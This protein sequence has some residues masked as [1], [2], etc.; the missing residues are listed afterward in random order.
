MRTGSVAQHDE[1]RLRVHCRGSGARVT[2]PGEV[3]R[4]QRA[5]GWFTARD[6]ALILIGPTRLPLRNCEQCDPKAEEYEPHQG[7]AD[8]PHELDVCHGWQ[9]GSKNPDH[10]ARLLERFPA[11]N[12]GVVPAMSGLVVI[13]LDANKKDAPVPEQY[14]A[15]GGITDGWDVFAA[16]LMRYAAPWPCDTLTVGTP[17]GGLHLWWKV[18]PDLTVTSTSAG[19]FG[20]LVDVRAAGSY[21]P[22]PGTKVRGGEYRRHGDVVEPADAPGWLLHHLKATGHMPQAAKPRPA[23]RHRPRADGGQVGQ[24]RLGRIAD[25]LVSAP[26]HTGHAALCTATTAAAHLVADGL[27]PEDE[28]ASVILDAGLSRNRAEREIRDAWRTALNK[29]GRGR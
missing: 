23:F 29:I 5:T 12:L 11:A 10:I 7:V 14:R 2:A 18:K 21:V 25:Q 22:A 17:S 16:V 9:A 24:E 13:D 15:A 27:V 6:C 26:A 4:K 3:A 19:Q 28:A 20:W 1:A 8:C